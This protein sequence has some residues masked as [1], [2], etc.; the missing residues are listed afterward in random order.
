MA[1]RRLEERFREVLSEK[2]LTADAEG[3]AF[4]SVFVRL[5]VRSLQLT[6]PTPNE[7]AAVTA[8]LLA[9]TAMTPEQAGLLLRLALGPEFR[10]A[11]GE[12]ELRVFGARF[13]EEAAARLDADGAEELDLR[14]FS[15]RH[16]ASESLLLLDTLFRVCAAEGGVTPDEIARL[17][18]ACL[19]LGVDGVLFTALLQKHDPR[20]VSGERPITLTGDR[21]VIG[22]G[23]GCD[24]VLAD[25]QVALRHA[26]L[27]RQSS[28][29]R[30]VDLGSGR[31]TVVNGAAVS[32]APLA[33]DASLRIGPYALSVVED[34]LV[35]QGERT[36]SALSVRHLRRRIGEVS[37]LD[38]VSFTV[39]SGEVV[40][41]VGP[42]GAGKT[43]LL[44]AI[45]GISPADGGE[46][47]LDG[48]DFHHLLGVD[49]SLVGVVPQDDLVNPELTVEE[50][51]F[52]SGRLRF[53]SDVT[54]AEVWG[55]VDRVLGELDIAH[56]R[57]SRIGDALNRGISGGQ[58]KRVN[59]GQELL[60]RSTRVLF[61]DEPTSGL[62]PRA[63]QD[64]VRLIRQLADRGR[65]IFLVTH[66]LTPEVMAQVD[67]LL[68]L[69]KGGRLAWFGPPTEATRAFG[70][71]TPDAIFSRFNDKSPEQ[72]GR[73]Y[74][75]GPAARKYVAT[76]E[77]LV[78]I[79]GVS[80]AAPAGQQGMRRSLLRQLN[81]LTRRYLRVKLRDRTGMA[82]LVVQPPVLAV[83]MWI[84]FKAPTTPMLFMFS[85]S[86]LWF[87]MSAGVRELISD[88]IIWQRERRVGLGVLPYVGSKVVVL[89]AFLA[90]Q[91]ALLS[92]FL[93][94]AVGMGAYDF[95]LP[96]MIVTTVLTGWL[97]IAVG[98]LVSAVWT[99]SEAAVGTLPLLLIPQITF[100]SIMVSI[101]DM[102][103]LATAA[104]WVT[105][106]RYCFDALI[107]CGEYIAVTTYVKGN[108]E[109][110]G[111]AGQLFKL[112]LRGDG[113]DNVGIPQ[114]VLLL[115]LFGGA[116]AL[117]SATTALVAARGKRQG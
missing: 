19:E 1:A 60:T 81:T 9:R 91:C 69:T 12:M 84:V 57:K 76:R 21:L 78:G 85:L 40:A 43:T 51:L 13:G 109:K 96:E 30:V 26:E 99:S 20:Y 24:V 94:V 42:S 117:L 75:E 54:D 116:L 50:S 2:G 37:L 86:C 36:F 82:V 29:W 92:V 98:L 8:G 27:V 11:I 49:R 33:A 108:W 77:H 46:V 115:L 110:Q 16:G 32:S 87:G 74:R 80:R 38:D 6:D 73:E 45:N 112:G 23:A 68:V 93:Y 79:E 83:V 114:G 53:S 56:I 111:F 52:Y 35:V 97:G 100:S 89:G 59:L 18:Q 70:V 67:H 72:W 58:R 63:S 101:R 107:K 113:A 22:R 4:A 5:V 41:L 90:I 106:Q 25:P 88:R 15:A 104:T 61:L 14:S 28:G 39:F 34:R 3:S 55:E 62:D 66:D 17:Q 65:I 44:N 64:I 31:P 10:S 47:L 95:S 71:P 102:G 105:F 48:A 103:P 7:R